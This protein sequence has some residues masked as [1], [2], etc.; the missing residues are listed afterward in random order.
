MRFELREVSLTR[1]GRRVLDRVGADVHAGATA[2]VGRAGSGKSTLLRLLNRLAD[3]D[4]GAI[5]STL[6]ISASSVGYVRSTL[7]PS[8]LICLARRPVS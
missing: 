8:S 5:A 4:S 3:P 2:I 6:R 7:P 1:G